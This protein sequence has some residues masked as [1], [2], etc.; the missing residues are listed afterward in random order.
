MI[1]FEIKREIKFNL[2]EK[3]QID[4][5]Y[6][7][8]IAYI[9]I[10]D[11]LCFNLITDSNLNTYF[12]RMQSLPPGILPEFVWAPA[13]VRHRSRAV[14]WPNR[15]CPCR[16]PCT[17]PPR[18]PMG[19]SIHEVRAVSS[20]PARSLSSPPE[21]WNTDYLFEKND[22]FLWAHMKKGFISLKKPDNKND[23][24]IS[25]VSS[26]FKIKLYFQELQIQH[27]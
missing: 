2:L 19:T 26:I 10:L 24:F 8:K 6:I 12:V 3:I 22:I 16:S 21:I 4:K 20:H 14:W 13:A 11:I 27:R 15:P 5:K 17:Q 1:K 9:I 7:F 18:S 23:A 25:C